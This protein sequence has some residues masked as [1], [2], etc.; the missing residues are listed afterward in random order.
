MINLYSMLSLFACAIY[1]LLAIFVINKSIRFQVKISFVLMFASLA[2]WSFAYAFIYPASSLSN[3]KELWFW[4][5]VSAIGWCTVPSA[6]LH[7]ALAVTGWRRALSDW[8]TYLLLYIP[9]AFKF[10]INFFGP[11]TAIGFTVVGPNVVEV[12]NTGLWMLVHGL[13]NIFFLVATTML[14]LCWALRSSSHHERMQGIIASSATG[15][16]AIL[17]L[18]SN[19][20]LPSLKIDVPAIGQ[21]L[22]LLLAFGLIYSIFRYRFLD[23]SPAIANQRIFSYIYEI[24]FLTNHRGEISWA[25]QQVNRLLGYEIDDLRGKNLASLGTDPHI[26]KANMNQAAFAPLE[27]GLDTSLQSVDGQSIPVKLYISAI[28]EM[29]DLVGYVA[30]AQDRRSTIQLEHEI[31]EKTKAEAAALENERRYREIYDNTNDLIYIHEYSGRFISANHTALQAIEYS[32]EEITNLSI[33][34]I[35]VPEDQEKAHQI[36]K[37]LRDEGTAQWYQISILSK[38][39]RR[40]DLEVSVR[41][42]KR[43]NAPFAL[44]CTARDITE[45][46]QMEARMMYISMH[47]AVTGLYN[48]G[49]FNEELLRLSNGRDWPMGLIICDIDGLKMVNDR[50]GHARGDQLLLEAAQ[51]IRSCFRQEDVVARLGGDEFGVILPSYDAESVE[52]AASRINEAVARYNEKGPGIMLGISVG[53]AVLPTP[54]MSMDEL[55]SRADDNMYAVKHSPETQEKKE[56]LA[57]QLDEIE[58]SEKR[59]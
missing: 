18:I 11:P 50:L 45:R 26:I 4:F 8:K 33:Y 19:L 56:R 43:N 35:V 58:S 5:Y 25:N 9:A 44:Q 57:R 2:I 29:N 46:R 20:W 53:W 34:D 17:A 42:I 59:F 36:M 22:S 10:G 7:F 27:E 24:V 28:K 37:I 41:V 14:I 30:I 38:N 32:L 16:S 13:Y 31:E 3:I 55:Y 15:I 52:S 48:R 49:F 1:I 6:S 40:I 12:S 21:I 23:I 47:D 51:L 54:Q 39:N